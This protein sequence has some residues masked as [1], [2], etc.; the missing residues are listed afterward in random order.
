MTTASKEEVQRMTVEWAVALLDD[1]DVTP[2]DNF[3][4]LG[5]HSV[6]ALRMNRL[7]KERW[8]VEYDL[9][10]LLESDLAAAADDMASR[11][12]R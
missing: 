4:D 9:M 11:L 3:I 8:G 5:G 6:L 2:E 1:P 12:T 7:A 10:V